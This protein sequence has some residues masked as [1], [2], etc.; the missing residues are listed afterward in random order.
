MSTSPLS[1]SETSSG[2]ITRIPGWFKAVLIGVIFCWL[3]SENLQRLWLKTNLFTGDRN[4][5]HSMMI[6]LIG[7]YYLWLRRDELRQVSVRPLLGDRFTRSRVF[8]AVLVGLGGLITWQVAPWVVP[9]MDSTIQPGAILSNAGLGIAIW[10]FL[11]LVL[12]WGLG[13]LLAGLLLSAYGIWPGQNDFVWDV[14]MILTLFGV[15]LTLCGWAVMKIVWFPIAFLLC[16]LPWPPLVYSALALPLQKIAAVSSVAIMNVLGV[17]A[18]HGGSKIFIAQYDPV[19]GRQLA[20]RA[21]NVAEA[22]AGLVSLMTFISIA[23]AIAFLSGRAMWQKLIITA[24]AVPIA[25]LC[26]IIRVAGVGMLDKYGG[27][28]WSDGFAHQ[29]AGMV[30]LLPAFFLIM[31][32]CWIVDQLVIEEAEDEPVSGSS[33]PASKPAGGAA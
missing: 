9:A 10:A 24:S 17:E 14:G 16:A 18:S 8:S 12:D 23:A 4:W 25:I 31:L 1:P 19:T 33:T 22:C 7:L 21:L 11:A 30:L 3:Y 28:E 15:V 27:R 13:S 20:D 26:N 6:P 29:F 32:V 2:R 5:S